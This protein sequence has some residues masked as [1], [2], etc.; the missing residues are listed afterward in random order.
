MRPAKSRKAPRPGPFED[1]EQ[2]NLEGRGVADACHRALW[3]VIRPLDAALGVGHCDGVVD[4]RKGTV[5]DPVAAVDAPSVEDFHYEF[6]VAV[7]EEPE[8][9]RVGSEGYGLPDAGAAIGRE[10]DRDLE[11]AGG[12]AERRCRNGAVRLHRGDVGDLQ[13]VVA[14]D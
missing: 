3:A 5:E 8:V 1:R 11:P 6:Y 4:V 13:R 7:G 2:G 12:Q 9:A 10:S 14:A